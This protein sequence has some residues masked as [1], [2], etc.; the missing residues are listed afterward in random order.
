[1]ISTERLT[2]I[3]EFNKEN[4]VEKTLEKFGILKES[5]S[6][7]ERAYA[8]LKGDK[9][10]PKILTFDVETSPNIGAFWSPWKTNI[11]SSQ[12]IRPW[13]LLT[14]SAKWIGQ[15]EILHD[16]LTGRDAALGKDY[17]IA[18]SL[19]NLID[20][21][22]IVIAHNGK[23]FD[24]K[25]LNTRLLVNNIPQPSP[26]RVVDTLQ[27]VKKRF[28]FTYN[29]LD[30]LVKTL[31]EISNGKIETD[32]GLWLDA[33]EGNE[34]A[35]EDMD[36][37]CQNDVL[38][39]EELYLRIRGWIPG[40]PNIGVYTDDNEPV[41][42][43]CGSPNIV[44]SNGFHVTQVG[45]YETYRCKDCGAYSKVRQTSLDRSKRANLLTRIP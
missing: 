7:Y 18:L 38:I 3:C 42:H 8:A 36:K 37:Y 28:A 13:H 20:E 41:C 31:V 19:R 34:A 33:I 39:L 6:R 27:A 35:L 23:K 16:R 25:R 10:M 32:M 5:L 43:V 1:M 12:I 9:R 45:R 26:Y 4:G 14:W 44:K 24:I 22:D 29:N 15:D 30:Y 11:N 40:H 21:A 2:E 17:S